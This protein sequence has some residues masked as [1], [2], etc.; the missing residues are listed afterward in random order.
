MRGVLPPAAPRLLFRNEIMALGIGQA[1][2]GSS[3]MGSGSPTDPADV[4]E[5]ITTGVR[6]RDFVTRDYQIDPDTLHVRQTSRIQQ[7]VMWVLQTELG[8]S[9]AAPNEG[10]TIPRKGTG[11]TASQIELSIRSALRWL[12]GAGSI[13]IDAVRVQTGGQRVAAYIDYTN[14]E[15]GEQEEAQYPK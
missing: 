8:S 13:T 12:V 3:Q 14:H 4:P 1:A 15:T 10:I 7:I 11:R 6:Y 5:G 9:T 2:M